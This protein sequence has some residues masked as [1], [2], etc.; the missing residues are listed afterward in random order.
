[1]S[2]PYQVITVDLTVA[3][4][5]RLVGPANSITSF[6]V[7]SFPAGNTSFIRLGQ[8]GQRI[9]V[10]DQMKWDYDPCYGPESEG[11]IWEVAVAGAGVAQIIVFTGGG[12]V[13]LGT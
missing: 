3:A 7:L 13:G 6:T 9:P 8:N 5:V 1:M 10:V 12:A 2:T 11:L 4:I